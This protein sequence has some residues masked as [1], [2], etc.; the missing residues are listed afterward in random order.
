MSTTNNIAVP[1]AVAQSVKTELYAALRDAFTKPQKTKG[2][3]TAKSF[4]E[5][6]VKIML[7][8]AR[9]NP[10][11][12][13]GTLI[14]RQMLQEDIISSLDAEADKYLARDIDFN[15]YRL[16]K[17]L[18]KEQQQVYTDPAQ[19]II[20]IGSRRIGK[21]ELSARL[22]VKDIL[23]PN[24]HALYIHTN[25]ENAINQCYDKVLNLV[26]SLGIP[27]EE[28]KKNEGYIKFYNSSDIYFKGNSDKSQAEKR[29]GYK[30][31]TIVIDEVQS[32]CNLPYL[33]DTI[34]KP[35]QSDYGD[36]AKLIC[37][38]TPPRIPHTRAEAI[39][40]EY[41]GWSKYSWD[42]SK[43]PYI[44]NVDKLLKDVCDEKG[45]TLDAPFIQR[46]W[47]GKFVY[48]YEAAV[49]KD[50]LTYKDDIRDLIK[51]NKFKVDYIYGGIDWGG[52][53]YN[54]IVTI[55]WDKTQNI[56]YIVDCY[57]FNQ[58]TTTE[59]IEKCNKSLE[60]SLDL[61]ALSHSDLHNVTY[62]ADHNIKSLIFEL[63][64]NYNFPIQLAY[65]HDKI[66]AI[67]VLA[68]LL[69]THIYTLEDS[70]LIEEYES[71]IYKRD[72][73]TDAILPEIDDDVYHPDCADA[74]LYASRAIVQ[75]ENPL[76]STLNANDIKD[77]V[78]TKVDG[79][80]TF[81]E[82]YITPATN[83]TDIED[84]IW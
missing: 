64:N 58:S 59:I 36:E 72:D 2:Q 46:E 32:Q 83:N 21:T 34:L 10:N 65:K 20:V 70:P 40:K 66:P 51:S 45:V 52:T 55:A 42:M 43:N 48:D 30:Y 5:D 41:K 81:D 74:L 38:G 44:K 63:Q 22:L 33:M 16:L 53:D 26:N 11:G 29:Q 78:Y 39:W 62:Y 15:E 13:I 1:K 82:S 47:L 31:S 54:A 18:Y 71:V 80:Q 8:Q 68:D 73:E 77:A 75:F 67:G 23:K 24:H 57:K 37:I 4:V 35:A 28:S 12:P 9:N 76:G 60:N 79:S 7:D 25:F 49:Y 27:V 19:K 50:A 61:L 69:R 84:N 14:A 17:T 6:Y 56:G 3:K